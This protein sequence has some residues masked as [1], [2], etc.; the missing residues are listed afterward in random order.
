MSGW[1]D[2]PLS[3]K[4]QRQADSLVAR[5]SRE[6]P[7]VALYSSPLL[8]AVQT[9]RPLADAG[10]A[11]LLVHDGLREIHCGDVDGLPVS[12]VQSHYPESW[13]ANLRQADDDFSWPG[14]ETY[15]EFRGRTLTAIEDLVRRHPASRIVVVTHAGVI[16]QLIGYLS[17]WPAARWDKGRPD[18]ASVTEIS[19]INRS[20]QVLRFNDRSHLGPSLAVE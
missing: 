18:N 16:S 9:A 19:W 5:L 12:L 2:L 15:A 13:A 1:T 7:I 4:G 20:G 14:G 17:G 10:L 6:P 8:R 11:E 3:R